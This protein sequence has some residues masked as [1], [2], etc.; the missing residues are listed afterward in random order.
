MKSSMSFIL[1]LSL[2]TQALTFPTNLFELIAEVINL[3][4]TQFQVI[5]L[6]P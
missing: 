5:I 1:F 6:F 4:F 3:I 2:I